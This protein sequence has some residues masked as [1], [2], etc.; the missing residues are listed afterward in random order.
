MRRCLDDSAYTKHPASTV[1]S[2]Y[3]RQWGPRLLAKLLNMT[4]GTTR[5]MVDKA[6]SNC[7]E[8]PVNHSQR[9]AQH[10]VLMPHAMIRWVSS[11]HITG[12]NRPKVS[13]QRTF[14][15]AWWWKPVGRDVAW[16]RPWGVFSTPTPRGRTRGTHWEMGCG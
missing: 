10:S 8:A 14:S 13:H 6:A 9:Q 15:R 1:A 16:P 5:R 11:P 4:T 3:I 12:R 7:A 2:S